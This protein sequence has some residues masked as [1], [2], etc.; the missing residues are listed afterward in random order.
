V[1]ES[2]WLASTDPQKM[3]EYLRGK[4]SDRKLRL[5]AVACVRGTFWSQLTGQARKNT[6]EVAEQFADGHNSD[7][8]M[9]SAYFAK[10][11]SDDDWTLAGCAARECA[12]PS[13]WKA[14]TDVLLYMREAVRRGQLGSERM[15]YGVQVLRC[16]V[17]TP[18]RPPPPLPPAIL[19]W[20][21]GT[22]KRIAEGAYDD[23]RLPEGILDPSRLAILAD[24]LLDAGCD[25]E[26][27]LSHLRSAGPHWRGCF[28]MDT[29]LGKS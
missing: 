7:A 29:C 18:F 26:E 23:R 28:A 8:E 4:A 11:L 17:G 15:S 22:V 9:G 21:D 12:I 13:A 6:V 27:L 3:L 24:A 20:N 5:F 10:W 19:A 1:T 16:I 25:D 2:E 14:L